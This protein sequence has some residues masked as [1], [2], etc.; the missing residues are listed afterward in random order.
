MVVL[1]VFSLLTNVGF[2]AAIFFFIQKNN[3]WLIVINVA[4]CLYL[5]IPQQFIIIIYNY[6]L[7]LL[8]ITVTF[9]NDKLNYYVFMLSGFDKSKIDELVILR[10]NQMLEDIKDAIEKRRDL[11]IKDMEGATAVSF[12]IIIFN[13]L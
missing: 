11:E 2:K 12:N 9:S 4:I 5:E 7:L 3:I 13:S 10:E 1:N 6:F 8:S